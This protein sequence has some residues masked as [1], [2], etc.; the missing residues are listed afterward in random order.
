ML[1]EDVNY[2]SLIHSLNTQFQPDTV[3]GRQKAGEGVQR[4]RR[5]ATGMCVS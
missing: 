5:G 3:G 1:G 4:S 2:L